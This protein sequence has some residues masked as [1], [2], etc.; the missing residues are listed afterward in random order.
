MTHINK[1]QTIPVACPHCGLKQLKTVASLIENHV[2]TCECGEETSHN[3]I[4]ALVVQA[5]NELK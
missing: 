5:V 1:L 3:D 4:E 2:V